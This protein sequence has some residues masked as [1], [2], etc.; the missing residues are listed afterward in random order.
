MNTH[1]PISPDDID[2]SIPDDVINDDIPDDVGPARPAPAPWTP[3]ELKERRR[4]RPMRAPSKY[5]LIWHGENLDE[6]LLEWLVDD[7]LPKVGT[8]L[9]VGQWGMYKSFL[10]LDLAGAVMTK[11]AFAGHAVR[12]QAGVLL[13]AA[14]GQAYVPLRL[15][16]LARETIAKAKAPDDAVEIRPDYMPLFW[17]RTCPRLAEDDAF[18]SLENI[19]AHAAAEMKDR[20]DLPLGLVIIDSLMP[21]AGF[22]SSSDS[23]EAQRVMDLLARTANVFQLL[24]LAVDHL[25]KNVSAGARDSSAKESAVDVVLAALGERTVAGKVNNPRLAV[26]KSRGGET[27]VVIPFAARKVTVPDKDK[28]F[29]ADVIDWTAPNGPAREADPAKPAESPPKPARGE[30]TAQRN[31]DVLAAMAADPKGSMRTWGFAAGLGRRAVEE[32]LLRLKTRRLAA[33]RNGRWTLTKDGLRMAKA[34]ETAGES[35]E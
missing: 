25:G 9:L 1:A 10:V 14:E 5:G 2:D 6:P 4:L 32:A 16:A 18:D 7:L 15:E 28:T 34:G 22:K 31:G 19:V 23:A 24:V 27:D 29:T 21:A 33:V 30:R 26:R 35:D 12:Q 17:R 8:A 20:F 3:E 11:T 13:I